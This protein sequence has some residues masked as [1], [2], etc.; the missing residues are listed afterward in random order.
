MFSLMFKDTKGIFSRDKKDKQCSMTNWLTLL[1]EMVIS[2]E[3]ENNNL[4][5][6]PLRASLSMALA[7]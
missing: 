6:F 1:N 3:N 7:T 5:I 2:S 4:F